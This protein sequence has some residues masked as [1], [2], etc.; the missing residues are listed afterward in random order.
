[1]SEDE[2]QFLL[3]MKAT[4]ERYLGLVDEQIIEYK[5][6]SDDEKQDFLIKKAIMFRNTLEEV[7]RK[8][9]QDDKL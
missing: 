4:M 9:N 2:R 7:N 5:P 3:D 1:M 6:K 8:L